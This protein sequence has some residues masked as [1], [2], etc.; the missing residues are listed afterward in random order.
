MHRHFDIGVN[1]VAVVS[2]LPDDRLG[3]RELLGRDYLRI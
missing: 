1:G 2:F 3:P